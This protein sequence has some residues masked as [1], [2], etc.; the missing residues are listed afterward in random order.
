[1]SNPEKPVHI[2]ERRQDKNVNKAPE[3]NHNIMGRYGKQLLYQKI[4]IKLFSSAGA[5]SGEFHLYRQMRRKEASR[6]RVSIRDFL[7]LP[8][9]KTPNV[10]IFLDLACQKSS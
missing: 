2:P 3:F 4:Y 1:M 6:T 8:F 10:F 7:I 5:G 9:F